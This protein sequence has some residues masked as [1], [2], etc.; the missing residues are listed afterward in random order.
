MVAAKAVKRV[1]D[2]LDRFRSIV[3]NT[4]CRHGT[5]YIN[6]NHFVLSS[7]ALTWSE[8]VARYLLVWSTFIG[9][10]CVYKGDIFRYCC[11][12]IFANKDAKSVDSGATA[13]WGL[14]CNRIILRSK[15][16]AFTGQSA[17][18]ST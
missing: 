10:G 4:A 3:Y 15:I 8:E 6:A 17:F 12:R 9:A 5:C 14:L 1:S 7:D 2:L 16:Y 18:C 11:A 13:V